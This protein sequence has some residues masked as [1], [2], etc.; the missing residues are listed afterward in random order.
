MNEQVGQLGDRLGF[1][2]GFQGKI[3][4]PVLG[5]SLTKAA[6]FMGVTKNAINAGIHG[7]GRAKYC[8]GYKWEYIG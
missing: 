8:K 7:Y 5:Q 4:D 3:Q 1:G 2:L 6:E